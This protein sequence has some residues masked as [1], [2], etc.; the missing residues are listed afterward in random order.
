MD[1]RYTTLTEPDLKCLIHHD[2][3]LDFSLHILCSKLRAI[4]MYNIC[5]YDHLLEQGENIKKL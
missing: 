5:R 4:C 3:S 2:L 1:K